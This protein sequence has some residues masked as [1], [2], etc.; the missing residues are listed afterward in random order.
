[1]S[2][3][4]GLAEMELKYRSM[5][6][7]ERLKLVER[8]RERLAEDSG[9]VFAYVHGGFL[10]REWFR[11]VDVAV[12]VRDPRDAFYYAVEFSAKLEVELGVPV[13][14]QVLNEAPLPFKYRVFTRGRLLFSR[15]ERLRLEVVDRTVR[16]YMDFKKLIEAT[17]ALTTAK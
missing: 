12:W 11:D 10:E 13:D 6:E 17:A 3:Y 7:C 9:V 16:S 2:D 14:V 8:L 4:A 15:D 1:M 5:P